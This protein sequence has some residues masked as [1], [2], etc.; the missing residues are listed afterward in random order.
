MKSFHK[1]PPQSFISNLLLPSPVPKE[2]LL[3]VREI[4][5]NIALISIGYLLANEA[6]VLEN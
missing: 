2:D 5:A 3:N 1:N 6:R 4:R